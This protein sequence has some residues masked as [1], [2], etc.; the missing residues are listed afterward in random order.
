MVCGSVTRQ[1]RMDDA[2]AGFECEALRLTTRE[3]EDRE[4]RLGTANE[5]EGMRFGVRDDLL[6]SPATV[7]EHHVERY[8][9]VLHPHADRARRRMHEQHPARGRQRTHEHEALGL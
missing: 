9:G 2:L 8:V 4:S 1:R 5:I 3:L 7:D 6:D